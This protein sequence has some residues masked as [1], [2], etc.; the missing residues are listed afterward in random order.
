MRY[1]W[2]M[3][4]L[5]LAALIAGG[6]W[7]R[8]Q[9]QA[10]VLLI[11]LDTT[12]ADRLG[13]YGYSL[14]RTPVLDRLA[15]EGIVFDRAYT[16]A[17]LTMP[18]H[19]SLLTGLYPQEHGL[20]TNGRGR[21]DPGLTSLASLLRQEGYDT[22]AFVASFVLDSKFGL[23]QG[24]DLYDDE[25]TSE[26]P[27]HDALHRQRHAGS[28]I[29]SALNW[30]CRPR[31]RPYFCWVHLYDP[32]AP[33]LNHSDLFQ[34]EFKH[35]P[36]DAE[37]AFVDSQLD[38][39]LTHLKSSRSD[40]NTLVIVVGDH[41]EG[42]GDHAEIRHGQTLY[43]STLQVPL[44]FRH[45]NT[46]IAGR[47]VSD[48]VSLVDLSPTI[49]DHLGV[50]ERRTITGRSLRPLLSG[51]P[52]SSRPCLGATDEPFL[53]SGWSPLR[54]LIDG[55]W[56]YIRTTKPELYHLATDPREERNLL[57]TEPERVESLQAQLADFESALETRVAAD[58]QLSSSERR[59]LAS[60]GY[61]GS[62]SAT[63][64]EGS[65]ADDLP[66]IKDMLPYDVIVE[67]AEQRLHDGQLDAAVEM[68]QSVL[69]HVPGH[70]AANWSLAQALIRQQ[71]NAEALAVLHAFVALRPES[72]QGRLGLGLTLLP[73]DAAAGIAE[74]RHAL[75]LDPERP[76]A[77]FNLALGLMDQQNFS[78]ALDLL[79]STLEN[80]PQHAGAYQWRAYILTKNN[81]WDAALADCRQWVKYA[82]DSPE[83]HLHLGQLLI[84]QGE[85]LDAD[86]H[87]ALA[88]ELAPQ[89]PELQFTLGTIRWNLKQPDRARFHMER[90]LQL[91]PDWP[92]ANVWV[93]QLR[94][95]RSPR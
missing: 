58:V 35:R 16:V 64:E 68:L 59:A 45:P 74:L 43:N 73:Q 57:E 61:L 17:P 42:L 71:K 21:L 80:D 44:I 53:E 82:S 72:Y 67:T 30:L 81:Q 48:P 65:F 9:R 7:F 62:Q 69:K 75:E 92:E 25:F 15:A 19:A 86:T 6:I 5:A 47:R 14:A 60:L 90:A 20:R 66:D 40:E 95:S 39:L 29:D 3:L 89:N 78:E 18:A 34:D 26:E 4:G 52:W 13:S 49:L 1:R 70:T 46:L 85:L 91:K 54:C 83:A 55:D 38:R 10:N 51:Q 23:D 36:Y 31:S 41:G 93:R 88:E 87:L 84:R 12:R 37:I 22:G 24:F 32:H 8:S 79:N 94:E 27:A 56:K 2:W 50:Q 63:R 76:E 28:V 11:T 33:Y 77:P